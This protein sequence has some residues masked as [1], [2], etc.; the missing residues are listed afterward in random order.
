VIRG[1]TRTDPSLASGLSFRG[2]LS[3]VP[4]PLPGTELPPSRLGLR[5]IGPG[6]NTPVAALRCAPFGCERNL[7]P[8][9][10]PRVPGDLAQPHLYISHL[11]RDPTQVIY[12][13]QL[14]KPY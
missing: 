9:R 8:L 2:R 3:E 11:A 4:R 12:L 7:S 5:E 6:H 14:P 13:L 1:T 10:P